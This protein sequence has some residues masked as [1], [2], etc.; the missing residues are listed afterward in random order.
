MEILELAEALSLHPNT[1]RQHLDQ[2]VEAG[3]ATCKTVSPIGRGRP[4]FC[5]A[6]TPGSDEQDP[7][8]YRELARVLAEQLSRS[9]EAEREAVEA[10]ENWG[11]AMAHD[12]AG[13]PPTATPTDRLLELLDQAGFAPDAAATVGRPIQLRHCP[14][15]A[16]A[17]DHG[18]VV[19]GVHLGMMRGIL[20]E[21]RAPFDATRLEPLVKPAICLVHLGD[22]EDG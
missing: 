16:L 21:L 20:Q 4:A 9:A 15:G 5:Y 13:Q 11:R 7:A 8:P 22:C 18:K 3:L 2:L 19:C 14:F 17:T 6:A 10:G 12:A 1:V